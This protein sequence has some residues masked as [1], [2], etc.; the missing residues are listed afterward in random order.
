MSAAR[1]HGL[2]TDSDWADVQEWLEHALRSIADAQTP[3]NG[4]VCLDADV[5]NADWMKIVR[6]R[7]ITGHNI[8]S[9]AALWLWWLSFRHVDSDYWRG[10]K[11]VCRE[12]GVPELAWNQD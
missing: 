4:A 7:R 2:L 9:W 10:V 11:K 3:Q 5:R 12:R 6:A 8:P 1:D